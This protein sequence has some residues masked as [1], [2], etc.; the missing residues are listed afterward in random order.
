MSNA[1]QELKALLLSKSVRSF[2]ALEQGASIVNA[3][4]SL[5]KVAEMRNKCCFI[6]DCAH[7][8]LA[9]QNKFS[10]NISLENDRLLLLT[11]QCI[12][13]GGSNGVIGTNARNATM[14]NDFYG[15]S[16]GDTSETDNSYETADE[17]YDVRFVIRRFSHCFFHTFMHFV[18][19]QTLRQLNMPTPISMIPIGQ[20]NRRLC[21][22]RHFVRTSCTRA[23]AVLWSRY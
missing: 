18:H 9:R 8:T 20:R 5:L 17:G 10:L 12:T 21:R 3:L 23:F 19:R 1:L 7:P 15:Q 22:R 11:G 6:D 2:D 13:N 4:Q 14:S 16:D